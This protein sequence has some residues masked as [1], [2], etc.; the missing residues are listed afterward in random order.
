MAQDTAMQ[1]TDEFLGVKPVPAWR[2]YLKWV[3]N[4]SWSPVCYRTRLA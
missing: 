3:L 4:G 2:R 1:T